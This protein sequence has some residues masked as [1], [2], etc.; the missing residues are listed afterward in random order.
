MSL[1][2]QTSADLETG[3]FKKFVSYITSYGITI[4]NI[5]KAIDFVNIPEVLHLGYA[6][7]LRK[8]V[9]NNA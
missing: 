4:S 1:I 2:N 5:E 7:A 9:K 6:M 3:V 8:A